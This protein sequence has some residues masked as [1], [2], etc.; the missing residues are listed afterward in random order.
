[1]IKSAVRAVTPPLIYQA[2]QRLR[3]MW[4][5]ATVPAWSLVSEWHDGYVDLDRSPQI[6]MARLLQERIGVHGFEAFGE[7]LAVRSML[8]TF[9]YVVARAGEGRDRVSILDFGGGLGN[10]WLAA[11]RVLTGKTLDYTVVELPAACEI[12]RQIFPQIRFAEQCPSGAFNLVFGAG[13]L[14]YV[15]DWRRQFRTL[16]DL[17]SPWLYI[18]RLPV[19]SHGETEMV[20]QTQLGGG[21]TSWMLN[22]SEFLTEANDF[23]LTL[24]EKF[25]F[26]EGFETISGLAKSP[27]VRGVLFRKV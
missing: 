3:R 22:E 18:A 27:I 20:L 9:A 16:A 13:S 8:V 7:S 19:F 24:V 15:Q 21:V 25:A 12:G 6:A 2:A 5:P 23:G 26:G 11:E 10:Y 14:Q 17:A 4:S 1:M